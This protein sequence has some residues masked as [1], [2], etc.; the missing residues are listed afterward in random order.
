MSTRI[1]VGHNPDIGDEGVDLLL[2]EHDSPNGTVREI[3]MRP[4]REQRWI[5]WGA[6][7]T[8]VADRMGQP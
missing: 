1:Y 5:T 4:G 6:P 2:T 7:V 8:L 3:A